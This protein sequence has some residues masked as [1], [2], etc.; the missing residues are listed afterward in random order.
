M[1][2]AIP[3]PASIVGKNIQF[4]WQVLCLMN[5]FVAYRNNGFKGESREGDKGTERKKE[6]KKGSMYGSTAFVG[7][8]CFFIVAYRLCE[9]RQVLG[10]ARNNKTM[11]LCDLFLGNGSVNIPWKR[12]FLFSPCTVVIRKTIKAVTCY[13][14]WRRCRIPPP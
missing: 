5:A 4:K 12:C 14:V 7:L 1:D 3:A 2:W 6:R 11:G 9:Q 10:N 13:P 8:G